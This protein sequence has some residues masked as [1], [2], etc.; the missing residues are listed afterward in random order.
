MGVAPAVARP[1]ESTSDNYTTIE[2][3]RKY[4]EGLV[5]ALELIAKYQDEVTVSSANQK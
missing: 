3:L 4:R 5:E 2:E 1:P